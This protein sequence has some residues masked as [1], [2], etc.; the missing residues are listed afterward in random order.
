MRGVYLGLGSNKGDR[1][2]FLKKVLEMIEVKVG[3]IV[4]SSSVIETKAW[5]KTDQ[6]DF[7]NM[8]IEV[9]TKLD[10]RALLE[11]CQRIEKDLGRVKCEKWGSRVIDID[12]LLYGDLELDEDDLKIPHPLMWKREFVMKPLKEIAPDVFCDVN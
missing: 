3:E 1:H 11:V 7:L 9:D 6:P 12:I 2:L 4:K 8:V 10:P 5:G